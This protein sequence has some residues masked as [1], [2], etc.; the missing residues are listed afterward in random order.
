MALKERGNKVYLYGRPGPFPKKAQE[1]GLNAQEV[2]F[3]VD[4]NPLAIWFFLQEFRKHKVDVCICNVSKDLRTAGIAAK[5]LGIPIVHRIGDPGDLKNR[6][7]TWAT[8]YLL[9]PRLLACSEFCKA[10]VIRSVP[11]LGKY[12]FQAIHPGVFPA[13]TPPYIVHTPRNVITSCQLDRDKGHKDL[14][15][16]L[17]KVREQGISF[18]CIVVGTGPDEQLVKE[19]CSSMGL[20]DITTFTG[21]VSNVQ[22][23]LGKGDIYVLPSYCEALGIALEEAMAQGLACIARRSGGVPEIWP[24]GHSS[25]LVQAHDDGNEMAEALYSLF[26]MP[27]KTLLSVKKDFYSHALQAFHIEEQ[28]KKVEEWLFNG[29]QGIRRA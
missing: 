21:Y 9:K 27:E 25:L 15:Y 3:G 13:P 19:Q 2:P 22:E 14:F 18:R 26:M 17:K 24:A 7:K 5:I 6:F 4:G 16:A 28:A 11:M 20:D 1:L 12:D 8:Q 23:Q 29:T 10:G